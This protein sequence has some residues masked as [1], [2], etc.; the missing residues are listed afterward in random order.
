[1]IIEALTPT[2][3]R[4]DLGLLAEEGEHD[5]SRL[6]KHAFW[7]IDPLDGTTNFVHGFPVKERVKRSCAGRD[8]L[9]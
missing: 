8:I 7:T 5:N 2:M 4:Y 3:I 1:M 9:Y 6:Q